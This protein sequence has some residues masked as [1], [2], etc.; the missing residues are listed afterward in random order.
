MAFQINKYFLENYGDAFH[1]FHMSSLAGKAYFTGVGF[2]ESNFSRFWSD[3][4]I[5]VVFGRK[6][7]NIL[8]F[9]ALHNIILKETGGLYSSIPERVNSMKNDRPGIGYLFDRIANVKASYNIKPDL[10]N[11]S[12]L[13]L[14][15][16]VDFN[17][18]HSS[19]PLGDLLAN[20][21]GSEWGTEHFPYGFNGLSNAMLCSENASNN[22]Y[23]LQADFYKFRG[24]GLIQTTG[25]S[26]YMLVAK[27]ILGYS[28][29][30]STILRFKKKWSDAPYNRNLD[31]ICTISTTE[32]WDSLFEITEICAKAINL[33][34]SNAKKEKIKGKSYNYLEIP[35]EHLDSESLKRSV[36]LVGKRVNGK[37]SYANLVAN[38]VMQSLQAMGY[39]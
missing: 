2:N 36:F 3:K 25:R 34:A 7:I 24:R 10:K 11:K 38:R 16:D 6:E 20:K 5:Q 4:M 17:T 15:H 29:S 19:K 39:S 18:A 13:T 21:A 23:I 33:H 9:L 26:N 30:N 35:L 27:F 22:G 28:G 32:E 37:D 8:E 31:K 12:C 14:F 1:G